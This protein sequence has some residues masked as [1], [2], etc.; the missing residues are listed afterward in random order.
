MREQLAAT[1]G[2]V[3]SMIGGPAPKG[4]G[5]LNIL[6]Q[7]A[8]L[9]KLLGPFLGF[10]SALAL[11][12]L[13]SR[14][15]HE[16]VALRAIWHCRSDFEWG[17]HVAFAFAAGLSHDEIARIPAG[18]AHPTWSDADRALL[19][20]TDEL[21]RTHTLCDATWAKL[22]SRLSDAELV[23]LPLIVGNYTMLSMVANATGVPLEPG[24]VPLPR[25][26]ASA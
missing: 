1:A 3:S 13:L 23:E 5:T 14:R 24:F 16:L 9:P 7:L 2:P 21:S 8:H 15:D 12:G 17:H 26:A 4:S 19:E 6:L 11:Q 22:R 18:P 20:A 25:D 10:A